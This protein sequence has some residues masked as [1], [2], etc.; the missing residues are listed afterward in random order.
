MRRPHGANKCGA[1]TMGQLRDVVNIRERP[2]EVAE[3]G[4]AR[5]LG[6]SMLLSSSLRAWWWGCGPGSVFA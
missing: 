1:K 2:A 4:R 3:P 6:I 5:P